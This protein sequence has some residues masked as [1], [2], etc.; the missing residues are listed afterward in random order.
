MVEHGFS[1][2]AHHG[3]GKGS[4]A[5][6]SG[7]GGRSGRNEADAGHAA[8]AACDAEEEAEEI[9][10]QMIDAGVGILL[11]FDRNFDCPKQLVSDVFRAMTSERV[12]PCAS[13]LVVAT[14]RPF[15]R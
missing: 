13:H 12:L 11:G 8:A 10:P 9:T 3:I 4:E 7:D 1:P 5:A 2:E 6:R 14:P 15:V